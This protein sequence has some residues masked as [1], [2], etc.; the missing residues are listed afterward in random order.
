[1]SLTVGFDISKVHAGPSIS[2]SSLLAACE[3]GWK[4]LNYCSSTTL[5]AMTM[6]YLSGTVYKAPN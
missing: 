2:L 5:A 3:S 1:M 6:N 4:T